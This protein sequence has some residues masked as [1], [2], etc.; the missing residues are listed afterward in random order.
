MIFKEGDAVLWKI[1][2]QKNGFLDQW[3]RCADHYLIMLPYPMAE[4][5]SVMLII[6][7]FKLHKVQLVILHLRVTLRFQLY[8]QPASQPAAPL[9]NSEAIPPLLCSS[10]RNK[11]RKLV[12]YF[13]EDRTFCRLS[14]PVPLKMYSKFGQPKW[15]LVS[16][17]LK[18]VGKWPMASYNF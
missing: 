8:I 13:W 17:M 2:C 4:H 15:I 10:V 3:Q 12:G 9:S 11:S 16:Q 5:F 1:F 18:L 6:L 7:M 14:L